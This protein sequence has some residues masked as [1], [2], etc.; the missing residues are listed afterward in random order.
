MKKIFIIDDC[1]LCPKWMQCKPSVSLTPRQRVKLQIG[2]G[3]KGILE[4]CPLED[5]PEETIKTDE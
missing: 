2:V 5:A 3:I 4:D 1:I